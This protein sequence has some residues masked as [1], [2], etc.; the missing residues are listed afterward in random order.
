MNRLSLYEI[1]TQAAVKSEVTLTLTPATY[2]LVLHLLTLLDENQWFFID[3]GESER[4]AT[5]KAIEE[6]LP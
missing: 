2:V 4:D 6:L 5:D 1:S 3:A